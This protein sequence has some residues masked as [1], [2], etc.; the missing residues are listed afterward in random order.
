[1][2]F[3]DVAD[4]RPWMQRLHDPPA[5][6]A[7]QDLLHQPRL[8]AA[9]VELCRDAAIRRAVQK[10]VAVQQVELHPP[11]GRLPHA[12]MDGAARQP[13]PYAQ[14][15][16]LFMK[17]WLDR[18]HRRVVVRVELLLHAL[19]VDDLAKIA[20]LVQQ[21]D[22]DNGNVEIAGCLQVIPGQDAQSAGIER[23]RGAEPEFHA[24]VGDAAQG[25][26]AMSGDE[27][28]RPVD[29]GLPRGHEVREL[30]AEG[31]IRGQ[32]LQSS[33]RG[34]LQHAPGISSAAPQPRI[35]TL[36][37]SVVLMAPGPAQIERKNTQGGDF[38]RQFRERQRDHQATARWRVVIGASM[39][40]VSRSASPTFK[41]A[42]SG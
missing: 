12:Q 4:L 36:P 30:L 2:A 7:E 42:S 13:E 10:I 11:H 31:H 37:E 20:L 16:A 38:F 14:P 9:S 27:P 33:R 3:V 6:D 26:P 21:S 25:R 22:P 24:E 35:D 5:A 34:A 40:R 17:D 19:G 8:G 32:T 23:Q 1:M 41:A 28:P 18:H 15:S 39:W 29:V